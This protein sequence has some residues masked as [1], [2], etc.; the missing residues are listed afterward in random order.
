MY[1]RLHYYGIWCIQFEE[2][3][4]ILIGSLDELFRALGAMPR[5]RI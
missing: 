2:G 3:Q 5:E 1:Y 4:E